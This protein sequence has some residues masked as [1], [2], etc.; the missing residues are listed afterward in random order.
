MEKRDSA[1]PAGTVALRRFEIVVEVAAV[2]VLAVGLVK[3]VVSVPAWAGYSWI[4]VAAI[5]L[6]VSS[7]ILWLNEEKAEAYGMTLEGWKDGIKT[8]LVASLIL[9]LLFWVGCWIYW[10]VWEGRAA[11]YRLP[12]R[13]GSMLLYQLVYLSLPEEIFFRGYCQSR[14]D[15][16]FGTPWRWWGASFGISLVIVSLLFA[17]GHV[18]MDGGWGR[19]NVFLPSLVFG[20]LRART[21]GIIA[22]TIFHGLSNVALFMARD[23]W[24]MT[25]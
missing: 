12:P 9:L 15:Q 4:L 1:E 16:A 25:V 8:G 24:G 23:F 6:A 14:L 19:F 5:W 13:L 7:F 17:L 10:G 21:S 2:F 18:V 22:P 20:W 3:G 11:T